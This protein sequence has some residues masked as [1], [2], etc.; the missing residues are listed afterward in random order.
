MKRYSNSNNNFLNFLYDKEA[1]VL[2]VSKGKPSKFDTSDEERGEVVVR[3]DPNTK[4][5]SGVTILNFSKKAFN[6]N[7]SVKLPADISLESV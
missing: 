1:D 5:V 7:L 6:Q 3:R 4:E 2:Y